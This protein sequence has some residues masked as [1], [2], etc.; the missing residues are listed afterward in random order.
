M[1]H[2]GSD[3][4]KLELNSDCKIG[5]HIC[6]EKLGMLVKL[7]DVYY[8]RKICTLKRVLYVLVI[9]GYKNYASL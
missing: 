9:C 4:G 5:K 3:P 8:K 1:F 2:R 7:F 6:Y